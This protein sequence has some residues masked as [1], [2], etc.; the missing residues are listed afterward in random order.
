[1]TTNPDLRPSDIAR[2]D[3]YG[4]ARPWI[5]AWEGPEGI[6]RQLDKS[7]DPNQNLWHVSRLSFL[8]GYK[9]AQAE[10]KAAYGKGASDMLEKVKAEVKRRKEY[11]KESILAACAYQGAD[12]PKSW[13]KEQGPIFKAQN[14]GVEDMATMVNKITDELVSQGAVEK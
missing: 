13:V 14:K 11:A 2:L 8:S 3:K 1:M 5:N 10:I 9:F 12:I 6:C 4:L 7:P